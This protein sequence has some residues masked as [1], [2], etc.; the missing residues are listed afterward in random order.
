MSTSIAKPV[1][2]ILLAFVALLSA[3]QN[4][5]AQTA[6][7]ENLTQPTVDPGEPPENARVTRYGCSFEH[8]NQYIT[9]NVSDWQ[10]A[11]KYIARVTDVHITKYPDHATA[12]A[13]LTISATGASNQTHSG[14]PMDGKWHSSPIF[15]VGTGGPRLEGIM[16]KPFGNGCILSAIG[17]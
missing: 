9:A 13:S 17:K 11:G 4:A 2:P 3:H 1:F 7:G 15:V 10:A 6:V 8:R 14:I 16:E 5:A 12:S